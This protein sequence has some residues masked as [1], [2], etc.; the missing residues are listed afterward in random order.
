M[1]KQLARLAAAL[2]LAACVATNAEAAPFTFSLTLEPADG[3]VSGEAGDVVGWGFTIE[4]EDEDHWLEVLLDSAD[5]FPLLTPDASIYLAPI[6]APL[7][8][9]SASFSPGVSGFY[10]YTIEAGAA[11]G[12]YNGIF[13]VTAIWYDDDP[14]PPV[15]GNVVD[16]TAA[17]V[18]YSVTVATPTGPVVPE[19]TTLLLMGTG[20][21]AAWRARLRTRR[22][23]GKL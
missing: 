7:G 10:Q 3:A 9:F 13:S 16:F 21:A 5:S 12:V 6:V 15:S 23:I 11:A 14:V 1:E 17:T 20:L 2:M 18:P 22:R 19:P 4:N 8:T